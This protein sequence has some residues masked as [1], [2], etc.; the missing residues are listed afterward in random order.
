[1]VIY[2]KFNA[3]NIYERKSIN[4]K[5]KYINTYAAPICR[6]NNH[7]WNIIKLHLDVAQEC[8]TCKDTIYTNES[9]M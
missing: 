1:M 9:E 8:E 4:K 3:Y 6:H 5:T 2:R 7:V